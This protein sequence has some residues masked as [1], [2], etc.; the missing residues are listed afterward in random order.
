MASIPVGMVLGFLI[1]C[2][3]SIYKPEYLASTYFIR[4]KYSPKVMLL[5][6]GL[7][8]LFALGG[9]QMT[10]NIYKESPKSFGPQPPN[11]IVSG[12]I[13][14]VLAWFII[15]FVKF[16]RERKL[17]QRQTKKQN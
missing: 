9:V 5:F 11:L 12:I 4:E 16:G 2:L 13:G 1:F 6:R 7:A 8:L 17:R 14:I 3:V 15:L 10:V